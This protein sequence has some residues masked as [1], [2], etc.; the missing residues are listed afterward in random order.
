MLKKESHIISQLIDDL[1]FFL[2]KVGFFVKSKEDRILAKGDRCGKMYAFDENQRMALNA[3]KGNAQDFILWHKRL[4]HASSRALETLKE[5][6]AIS[7]STWIQ[8]PSL[9]VSFQ[10]GKNCKLPFNYR[11]KFLSFP[12]NTLR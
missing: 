6:K 4:G 9:C 5:N 8:K 2:M 7:L 10:L 3:M 1:K 11:L 12:K